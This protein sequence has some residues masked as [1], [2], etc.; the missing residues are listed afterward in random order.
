MLWSTIH[1]SCREVAEKK[2]SLLKRKYPILRM[3]RP[4][5]WFSGRNCLHIFGLDSAMLQWPLLL[6]MLPPRTEPSTS[7]STAQE[8]CDMLESKI[9][10]MCCLLVAGLCLTTLL[11]RADEPS[12][13]V[14]RAAQVFQ[15]LANAE[16][17]LPIN[18]LN[19]ADCVIILPS[20]KKVY[21]RGPIWKRSDGLSE[22]CEF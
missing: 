11:A 15:E 16:S 2:R 1:N 17:G 19:K 4:H 9:Q 20:V 22:W 8:E 6:A 21:R 12:E 7:P 18:V 14:T 5:S 10:K 13:R 3:M